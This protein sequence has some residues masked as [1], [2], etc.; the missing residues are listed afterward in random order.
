MRCHYCDEPAVISPEHDGV[1]VG[2][3]RAHAEAC[4]AALE[5]ATARVDETV[6]DRAVTDDRP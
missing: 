1:K 2:L 4:F 5:E 3:C 6:D